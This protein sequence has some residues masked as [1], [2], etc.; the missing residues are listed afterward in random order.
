MMRFARG[1]MFGACALGMTVTVQAGSVAGTGGS[2]EVTQILNNVQLMSSYAQLVSS[3]ARQG[4]QYEAELKHLIAN[5]SSITPTEVTQL[6]SGIGT[7][8]SAGQSMGW[9]SSQ[10]D[11]NYA[12]KY[13]STVASSYATAFK[14]WHQT[15]LDTF[16]GVLKSVG[17]QRDQFSSNTSALTALYNQ[18]QATNG[19][20]DSLQTLSQINVRN[21]QQLQ[22]LQ[23]LMANQTTA[24]TTYMATQTAKS[25]KSTDDATSVSKTC[26]ACTT[27]TTTTSAPP[28]FTFQ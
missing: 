9:T 18:S 10:I 27:T 2:T 3:Y 24:E 26:S 23:E 15:N 25:Q 20:L 13:Q 12:A 11:T 19:T 8:M 28:T 1:F 6:I 22:S 7:A 5:P 16:A 4:L 21:V 14:T 17:L